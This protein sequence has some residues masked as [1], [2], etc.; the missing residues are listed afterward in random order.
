[1]A[2]L[3]ACTRS[4]R[5]RWL[6][7]ATNL[8][9]VLAIGS[10][11]AEAA[12][13]AVVIPSGTLISPAAAEAYF[14]TPASPAAPPTRDAIIQES[15]RSLKYDVNLIYEHV[16]NNVTYLPMF[17]MQKGARGVILDGAGT[18]FDQAQFMVDT[19]RESDAVAG[20]GYSPAYVMGQIT[21]NA[22]NFSTWTGVT[23]ATAATKLLAN[24]GIPATVTGTG[25]NFTV[26]MLHVW[27]KATVGGTVHWYDPSLKPK[28]W[29]AGLP[30]QG[31]SSYT[32]GDLLANGATGTAT[33]VSGFG[34]SA[35][36]SRLN[37]YRSQVEGY[38]SANAAGRRADD[39]VGY[40]D[41]MPAPAT[42]FTQTTL[43][44]V[45]STDATWAGQVPDVYRTAFTVSL[46]GQISGT[47]FADQ[48][49]DS[50]FQFS[51]SYNSTTGIFSVV[52][53][54]VNG[55]PSPG[56]IIS[57]LPFNECEYYIG[58]KSTSATAVASVAI[59]HP[60]ASSSGAYADRIVSRTL[61]IKPCSAGTFY[62]TNDWG[63]TSG[64]MRRRLT[65]VLANQSP[66]YLSFPLG[67]TFT[68]IANQYSNFLDFSSRLLNNV[69]QIHDIVGI[70]TIDN[71]LTL[72]TPT[73]YQPN[74][75]VSMDFE[76]A[77][78]TFSKSGTSADDT[79]AA[80]LAGL[81]LAYAES[82][83]PRQ[84]SDAVYDLSGLALLTQQDTRATPAGTYSTYL[85][86]P[87][88]WAS[89]SSSLSGY[90]SGDSAT[91]QGYIGEGYSVLVPQKGGLRQPI[92]S[93]AIPN[94]QGNRTSALWE[95]ITVDAA[96]SHDGGEI[97]RTA[98]LA[99]HNSAGAGT[100]PDRVAIAMYDPRRGGILKAGIGV[101][102]DDGSKQVRTPDQPK[103]ESK[104]IV[105]SKLSIDP[106][107]GALSVSTAVDLVDGSGEFPASLSLQRR[108]DQKDITNYGMGTGWKNN[109]VQLVTL[110]NNGQALLG[111]EG[112]AAIGSSLVG[113]TAIHDLVQ[114]QD[115][116]GLYSAL[117]TLAWISDQGQNNAATLTLGLDGD[118]SFYLQGDQTF[119][120]SKA[121]GESLTVQ[122][123]PSIGIIDRWIYT[124][125][126]ATYTDSRGTIRSYARVP[127]PSGWDLSSPGLEGP[128]T[129]KSA[130]LTTWIFPSGIKITASYNNPVATPQTFSLNSV[131]NSLARSITMSY[132]NYGYNYL[133]YCD[134]MGGPV[135]RSP[136]SNSKIT[137]ITS[138]GQQASFITA[139]QTI[140]TIPAGYF[141]NKLDNFIENADTGL[142]LSCPPNS[143][144]P[145]IGTISVP[146]APLTSSVAADGA[147]WSYQSG[148]LN[149][150]FLASAGGGGYYFA[151]LPV[152]T[153]IQAPGDL[154]MS[155]Q[156]AFGPDGK[157]RTVTDRKGNIWNYYS[158]LWR[159]EIVSP[160]QAATGASGSATYFDRLSRAARSIDPQ[161]RTTT[162]SYD[163]AS[164]P[165][166]V[167]NPEGDATVTAYDV[168][169]NPIQQTEKSKPASG[170]S[171]LMSSASYLET[172]T[173]S[174]CVN[175]VTCNRPAN[176]ID[177]NGNRTNYTWDA[178]TGNL[179]TVT[180]G[181]NSAGS[182]VL[183]GSA[184]PVTTFAYTPFTGSDGATFYLLS[185][186]TEKID[187][188][189][190]TTTAYTYNPSNHWVVK[191]VVTDSAGLSL[192]AC[193]AFD[194]SGN[195]IS[196]T[197]PKAGL[198]ACP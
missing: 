49:A 148:Q 31:A 101:P 18:D 4:R 70:H 11:T 116:K 170:L 180:K 48:T 24:G 167:T 23:T 160:V 3:S 139:P 50:T 96:G 29:Y 46:N 107:I 184:C 77:V 189:N 104:D 194:A 43:P 161:G 156:I 169:S 75:F 138:G 164:R 109:W 187:A 197:K 79:A 38:I 115:A 120:S 74:S 155:V 45:I 136:G 183:A 90:G 33:S 67:T 98:F 159:A 81:G 105:R 53:T 171:D 168:R 66:S 150:Q 140:R 62:V 14:G 112:A 80:Y 26:T 36:R 126:A 5:R 30:W 177:A 122:G 34:T 7:L 125:T 58:Y 93:L 13:P 196:K 2:P 174:N 106:R 19:L 12:N 6:A 198:T 35:F 176:T 129:R 191:S 193:F 69:Y 185:T 190:F 181:L 22:A 144:T 158:S 179:L 119:R 172:S 195:L 89:L 147:T 68:S 123:A 141:Y 100:P 20:K 54:N 153:G 87:S 1:M 82:S 131:S 173:I 51:Y 32:P 110:S 175:R 57:G 133:Y 84:E 163:P 127:P 134:T 63:F 52:P 166:T 21:L 113:I 64:E 186:K 114:T 182:C 124:N 8:V 56:R 102:T 73:G 154:T 60:Y 165:S 65:P 121:D 157:A 47:Y 59:N 118:K 61:T 78:S 97:K 41:I 85:A 149:T 92:I 37:S 17:G 145:P 162:T 188:S 28:V 178:T 99:W 94:N 132:L 76:A 137:F 108:Y 15:A 95:G 9:A 72:L 91:V 103:P 142:G 39:I 25:T 44:F 135:Q 152:H 10:R 130:Y 192:R 88:T 42:D 40:Y 55:L 83:V 146:F 71:A 151:S 111:T 143:L 16:R 117:Q 27:V 86:T 128:Y